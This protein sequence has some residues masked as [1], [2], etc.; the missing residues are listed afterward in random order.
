MTWRVVVRPEVE[1]EIDLAAKW[2][3]DE[4]PGLGRDFATEVVHVF[5]D[6]EENPFLNA[7]RHPAK[8]IRWR[9]PKRF[10]YRIVYEVLETDRTVVIH[11]VVHAARHERHW[12]RRI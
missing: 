7:C 11:A 5:D 10:P 12:R 2:Y 9:S 4:R 6:L 8:N 1:E 3:D